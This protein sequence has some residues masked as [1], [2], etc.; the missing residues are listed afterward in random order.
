M[1]TVNK[2]TNY[3]NHIALVLDASSSMKPHAASLIKVADNQIAYLAKRSQEMSQET[4]ITVYTFASSVECVIF[5]MDVLRLPSIATLYHPYGNTALLSATMLSQ[6]DLAYT[7]VKY[8]D[9][10]FLTF[11][12]TD[13]E[14][15]ASM[16]YHL[17]P[18]LKATTTQVQTKLTQ[19]PDNYSV[20]C[21]VPNQRGK[22]EA[23][24]IG[25]PTDNIQVWD[26]SSEQGIAEA[27]EI[28]RAATD[29]YMTG[30]SE[31][32][33]KSTTLFSTSAG[34]VNKQA[35]KAAKLKALP[36]AK[37]ELL[38]VD[39]ADPIREWVLAKGHSFII[40]TCYYQLTKRETIQPQKNIAL[41][42][43]S[44]GKIFTGDPTA[45]RDMLG[46]PDNEVR[47]SPDFNPLFDVF[48]QSTSVNRKLVPN[49]QLLMLK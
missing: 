25:F 3:I 43:K 42:E 36:T 47:V 33:R 40:G 7:F 26:S 37:Y 38:T 17:P 44:S 35:V 32:M 23:K 4:R 2:A 49:T 5:D 1:N 28:I 22:F 12:L 34:T 46:L 10:A 9:H 11:V 39:A 20:A 31:G 13:G 16:G 6:N 48:V 21:L 41:R 45:V 29:S 27:G 18:E 24:R 30:R 15:N 19:L 14:E 8:G